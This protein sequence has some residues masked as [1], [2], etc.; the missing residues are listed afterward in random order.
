MRSIP[1]IPIDMRA[2]GGE[3]ARGAGEARR[4]PRR[5][6]A[7]LVCPRSLGDAGGVLLLEGHVFGDEGLGAVHGEPVRDEGDIERGRGE[8]ALHDK[9]DGNKRILAHEDIRNT[10][11][12]NEL[13]PAVSPYS[14]DGLLGLHAERLGHSAYTQHRTLRMT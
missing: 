6:R 11:R 13:G 4:R 7:S 2:R 9:L 12:A 3:G 8:S 14:I 1:S 5:T 10:G